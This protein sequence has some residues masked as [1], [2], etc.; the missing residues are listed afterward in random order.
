MSYRTLQ[1]IRGSL[2]I[3][4]A[5]LSAVFAPAQ[6]TISTATASAVT[7][8]NTTP[9]NNTLSVSAAG[10]IVLPSGSSAVAVTFTKSGSISNLG[11]IEQDGTGRAIRDNT[12]NLALTVT[13]GSGTNSTASLQTADAD[14]VQMNKPGSAITLYNYGSINSLNAS[15]GGNQAIDWNALNTTTG[16]NTLYNYSTGVI[17]ATEADAVRPGVNGVIYNDGLIKSTTATGSGSDGIDAQTNSGVSITNAFGAGGGTGTGTIEGG[18][19]GITGGDTSGAAFTMSITNNLGGTIKGDDGAGINIDGVN[20]SEVVTIVNHGTISGNGVNGD[21]DG[22][23]VDG[24]VALTNTGT[25][26]SLNS[27]GDV[28][29]G[30]TVGGGTITNS[31]TIEGLIDAGDGTGTGRGITIAGVDKDTNGAPIPTQA[32][33]AATTIHN[34]AGGLI[35]GDSDSGIAFTSALAGS[36]SHTIDNDAGATIRGGG[37]TVAAIVTGGDAVTIN[38]AGTIDGSSSGKA[39][40]GGT[41]DLTVNISGGSASVL[42]GI[43]GGTGV[44]T[45]N[46]LTFDLG[47]ANRTFG[48]AGAIANFATVDVAS[49][50]VTLAGT[51]SLAGGANTLTVAGGAVLSPGTGMLTISSGSMTVDGTLRFELDGATAAGTDYGQIVFGSGDLTLGGTSALDLVLGYTPGIGDEFTL[52]TGASSI[53][54]QFS[55]LDEGGFIS[56]GGMTFQVSYEGGAGHDFTLTAVSAVPESATWAALAGMAALGLAGWHRRR[57]PGAVA[58]VR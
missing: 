57:K 53:A 4:A 51:V 27:H 20:A 58:G 39:I 47:A 28:S 33:C 45:V 7:L 56:A 36:Y 41:G 30:V 55:G 24:I 18:R 3:L 8:S 12:G 9:A 17:T 10:S 32:P 38:N 34:E 44:G 11:T 5:F 43:V 46:S 50:L 26:K 40:A 15:A 25:I 29:E 19:H 42:G 6:T 49:G 48:Y 22:V 37:T 1:F 13:N 23:D 16:S 52:I 2:A 21:G 14:V 54:G 35:K 31:G